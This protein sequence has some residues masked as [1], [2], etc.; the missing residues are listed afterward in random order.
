MR[1]TERLI[2]RTVRQVPLHARADDQVASFASATRT[3]LRCVHARTGCNSQNSV[4]LDI[5]DPSPISLAPNFVNR[6][7]GLNPRGD[8]A[9]ESGQTQSAGAATGSAVDR[10]NLR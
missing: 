7:V 6:C 5:S 2:E 8:L 10:C 9:P 4:R 1:V 3:A